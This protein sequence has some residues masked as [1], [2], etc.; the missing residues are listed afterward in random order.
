MKFFTAFVLDRDGTVIE[1]RHYLHEPEGVALMPGAA[2]VLAFFQG[3]GIRLF[4]ASNQSGVGRGMFGL[5]DVHKC[6]ARMA[7]LLLEAGVALSDMAF[8]PHTPEDACTCRK[9]RIGLWRKL[10]QN[11]GLKG[12]TTLMVGDKAADL[13]F[14]TK[15]GVRVAALLLTGKGEETAK[16]LGLAPLPDSSAPVIG[17]GDVLSGPGFRCFPEET[18]EGYPHIVAENWPAFKEAVLLLDSHLAS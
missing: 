2:G 17:T 16:T 5:E 12:A 8:C 9:P 13:A 3:Q 11:N 14:A 1:D 15:A 4:L 6:N 10:K 18:R 7:E